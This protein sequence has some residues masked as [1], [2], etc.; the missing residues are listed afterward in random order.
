MSAADTVLIT[1][2]GGEVGQGV[3]P[4]LEQQFT[5]R[6]L[7]R[8]H[9]A[10]PRAV[11]AD[12]L[13]WSALAAAMQGVAV[14]LHLAVASGHTGTFEE[15]TF[16]DQRF[17]INVK[18]TYHVFETA[19]RQRVR[20]VVQISSAMVTWGQAQALPPAGGERVAGNAAP[21]PVGTYALTKSLGEEI[22]RHYAENHGLEVITLRITAPFDVANARAT[23]QPVRPQQ[24]PFPDLAQAFALALTVP[25][26]RYEVVTIAGDSTLSPWS[27]EQAR[28]VL[29]YRPQYPLDALG[30][31]LAAPFAVQE[32]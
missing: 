16:N 14:V 28:Q 20:R 21:R 27:L 32:R 17:D 25:L 7:D 9:S 3:L 12:L 19:R 23:G 6:L 10:D 22:A 11:P 30:L 26:S 4:Y 2:A 29:G 18:G 1:G 15:D 24:V 8:K 31:A 5:L 13:D